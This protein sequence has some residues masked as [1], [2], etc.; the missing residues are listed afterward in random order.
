MDCLVGRR[1]SSQPDLRRAA[2][3]AALERMSLNRLFLGADAVTAEDAIYEFDPAETRGKE[4][5]TRR[6][7]A[8]RKWSEAESVVR[9]CSCAKAGKNLRRL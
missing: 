6:G 9:P 8:V 7:R 5:S 3:R 4:F 1:R 2:G